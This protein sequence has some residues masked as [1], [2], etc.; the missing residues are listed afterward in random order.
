MVVRLSALPAGRPL[1]PQ[2]DSWYSFLFR[3]SVDPKAIVRLEGL[4]QLKKIHPIGTRT[5]DFPACSVV[6]QPT[7]LPRAPTLK[8]I[9][10]KIRYEFVNS[11]DLAY[12]RLLWW[13]WWTFEFWKRGIIPTMQA[14]YKWPLEEHVPWCYIQPLLSFSET[15]VQQGTATTQDVT[16]NSRGR[17]GG[18]V[19]LSR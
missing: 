12:D 15:A 3:G 17:C 19:L 2:E 16:K 8:Q 11:T 1:P 7:T 13:R 14:T 4:G 6:P 18:L 5:R 10:M 9:L